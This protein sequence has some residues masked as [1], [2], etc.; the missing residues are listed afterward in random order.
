MP[1]YSKSKIYKLVSNHTNDI[2]IGST[3]QSLSMRKADINQ[4]IKNM[5]L[6]NIIM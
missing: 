5:F 2:Y 4:I 1:D 6:E 3:C